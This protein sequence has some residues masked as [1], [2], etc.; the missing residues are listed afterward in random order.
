MHCIRSSTGHLI[1][2]VCLFSIVDILLDSATGNS[3]CKPRLLRNCRCSELVSHSSTRNLLA[4]EARSP[5]ASPSHSKPCLLPPP[6]LPTYSRCYNCSTCVPAIMEII[7][8]PD[9]KLRHLPGCVNP[10]DCEMKN[11]AISC[12]PLFLQLN[13]TSYR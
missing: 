4:H 2:S 12:K 10:R 3:Q 5:T 11:A 8:Y 13:F 9:E 1:S 6:A 7:D